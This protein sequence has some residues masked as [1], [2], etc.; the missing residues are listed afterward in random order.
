[1]IHIASA[2][3]KGCCAFYNTLRA[4]AN[5]KSN[6]SKIED[7]WNANLACILSVQ[8]WDNSWRLLAS[9]KNN[10]F[11]KWIQ[12]QTLRSS[13]FTNNRVSK[14]KPNVSDQCDFCGDHVETPLSLFYQCEHEHTQ[15]F[16][17][18][19]KTFLLNFRINFHN[20]RLCILFGIHDQLWDSVENSIILLGKRF[21][22]AAKHKKTLPNFSNFRNS[23]KD[24]LAVLGVCHTL[25]HT[26]VLFD[27][28]WASIIDHLAGHQPQDGTAVPHHDVGHHGLPQ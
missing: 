14:F 9:I 6:T 26:R 8:F 11:A 2:N 12:C 20:S 24:Y 16:W 21:I 27:D 23:L 19:V 5:Q 13:L 10:N 25:V 18:E 3:K 4:R 1:M 17:A 28:Q 22:W 15:Q 7:K